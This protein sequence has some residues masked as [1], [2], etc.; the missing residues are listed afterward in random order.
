MFW[1]KIK[2]ATTGA[3]QNGA[4]TKIQR[5]SL[6]KTYLTTKIPFIIILKTLFGRNK[7]TQSVFRTYPQASPCHPL[8]QTT[9]YLK[10][11]HSSLY[12]I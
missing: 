4:G 10:A 12:R 5:R 1:F 2:H 9:G 8:L 11:D 3:K 6:L 7:F